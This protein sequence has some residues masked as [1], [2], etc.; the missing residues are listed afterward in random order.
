MISSLYLLPKAPERSEG[1]P[2]GLLLENKISDSILNLNLN[3]NNS[4]KVALQHVL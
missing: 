3:L 1:G 4:H 2:E